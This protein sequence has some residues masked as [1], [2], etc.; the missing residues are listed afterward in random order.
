MASPEF[1]VSFWDQ[2]AMAR[3]KMKEKQ[4]MFKLCPRNRSIASEQAELPSAP[5]ES[6]NR[7]WPKI[8]LGITS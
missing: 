8:L 1:P 2:A 6:G 4:S 7:Q 5:L 3:L